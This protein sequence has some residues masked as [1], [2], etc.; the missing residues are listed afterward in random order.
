VIMSRGRSFTGLSGFS[1]TEGKQEEVG[2]ADVRIA[3]ML[4]WV[5]PDDPP[6]GVWSGQNRPDMLTVTLKD[7]EARIAALEALIKPASVIA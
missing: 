7:F 5:Q 4:G 6:A 1:Y 3:L 2:P